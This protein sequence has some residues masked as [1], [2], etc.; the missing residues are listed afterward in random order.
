MF[1]RLAPVYSIFVILA[2]LTLIRE[3][4]VGPLAP[5]ERRWH[6]WLQQYAPAP[7]S[8]GPVTLVE[9]NDS[10]LEKHPWPWGPEDFSLFFHAALPFDPPLLIVESPLDFERGAFSGRERQPMFESMLMD[11]IHRSPRLILGGRLGW[12][13]DAQSVPD[14]QPMPVVRRVKGDIS[15]IPEFTIVEAW[16]REDY[17][18]ST[19]PG[20]MNI[21]ETNPPTA[22]FP[23]VLRYRGQTVPSLV[24][25]CLMLL[26]KVTP[27]EV[28]IVLGSHV[29]VG[30]SINIPIDAT[31][32]MAV[33]LRAPINRAD[34]D[35]FVLTRQQLDTGAEPQV[36]PLLFKNKALFLSRSDSA[37]A[38]LTLQSGRKVPG[39]E[40]AAAALG[41]IYARAWL[42]KAG[43]YFDWALIGILAVASMWF[44]RMKWWTALVTCLVLAG[45]YTAAAIWAAGAKLT[46]LPGILPLGIF[47]LILLLRF[48]IPKKLRNLLF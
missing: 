4:A 18:L 48:A 9:I 3:A 5:Y 26:E 35:T 6:E 27:D 32:R 10:T 8:P 41:T 16:A 38:G 17:R 2:G 25:Q 29:L 15:A 40:V 19:V 14:V 28:E 1:R 39:G 30:E 31:G 24:L 13:Q 12:S 45:G 33:N 44:Q 20:W 36:S 22:G 37:A 7:G 21:P 23:L 11:Q 43:P 47:D 46:L 42:S 34:F